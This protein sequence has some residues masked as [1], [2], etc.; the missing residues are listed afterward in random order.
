MNLYE[1]PDFREKTEQEEPFVFRCDE[2]DAEI[3]P[4]ERFFVVNDWV[5]CEEC[6]YESMR[7]Y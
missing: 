2:C 4:G 3:E 7:V 6:M 1:D 5:L